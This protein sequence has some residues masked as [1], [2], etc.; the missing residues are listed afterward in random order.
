[1]LSF[2]KKLLGFPTPEEINAAK[3]DAPYKVEPPAVNNKTGDVVVMPEPAKT[4]PIPLVVDT[5]LPLAVNDQI[6]DAVTQEAPAKKPRK[7]RAPK[8][9][10]VVKVKA[11]KE[12]AAK[13]KK[14]AAIRVSRTSKKV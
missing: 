10:K 2:I 4:T 3:A 12:K 1:M 5:A 7:P 6:T 14:P 8:T 13:A 11:T 9:E